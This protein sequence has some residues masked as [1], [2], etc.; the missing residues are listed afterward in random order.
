MCQ[1]LYVKNSYLQ[2]T[3][4]Q[5]CAALG[6][7]NIT[8]LGDREFFVHQVTHH[9]LI[10]RLAYACCALHAHWLTYSYLLSP[11]THTLSTVWI[12]DWKLCYIYF[13]T[14]MCNDADTH[15]LPLLRLNFSYWLCPL[16]ITNGII[17]WNNVISFS[18]KITAKYNLSSRPN[19]QIFLWGMPPGSDALHAE[20]AFLYTSGFY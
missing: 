5:L 16:V 19:L 13:K 1:S 15:R 12:A 8:K 17:Y 4:L 6:Q 20:C 2:C 10:Y 11:L 3:E 14:L 18:L 9:R 7:W